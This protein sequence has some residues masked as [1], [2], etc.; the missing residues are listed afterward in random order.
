[1]AAKKTPSKRS[2]KP[3]FI[4]IFTDDQGYQDVGCFGSPLIKTPHLDRMAKEGMRFTDFYSASPVC[5]PSRA[6]LLT[7]CYPS[8]LGILGALS[9]RVTYGLNPDEITIADLLKHQGYATA[10]V[11]KWHLGHHKPFLPKQQG[12]DEF[13]GL[14]YSNDMRPQDRPQDPPLH[15]IEGDDPIETNPDQ[16]YLTSRY[17]ARA[18]D[19]ITRSQ[20]KPFFLYLSHNMPHIPLYASEKFKGTS[21]RGL[22]GDVV[23]EIDWS[24]GQVLKTLKSL[25]LDKNTLVIFTSDNGPWLKKGDHGGSALPLKGGKFSTWE[26]GMREPTIMRWPGKIPAGYDCSEVCSTIDLLPTLAKLA[27]ASVPDDRVI[28]GKDIWPL[29]SG[30]P[31]AK[32]PHEAFFYYKKMELQAVRVGKWKLSV[33]KGTTLYDL[34]ADIGET[35]NLVTQ[36]PEIVVKLL[37][38]MK[39]FDEKLKEN[40]RPPGKLPEG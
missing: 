29:L 28:D 24:V 9:P 5:S 33:Y 22:Y 12:F 37:A 13:F 16:R 34:E 3:N 11:G 19:F 35:K 14:P 17:T 1:M 7:G 27:A 8:R 30:K 4:I 2:A 31:G 20:D 6:A 40:L 38:I 18:I 25:G 36:H 15:M 39:D 23:T 21:K 32:S 26:G 10:C